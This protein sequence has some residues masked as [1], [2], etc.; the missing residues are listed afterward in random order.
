[1]ELIKLRFDKKWNTLRPS[2]TVQY[3][4]RPP[5]TAP[6]QNSG[7]T[8]NRTRTAAATLHSPYQPLHSYSFTIRLSVNCATAAPD[9]AIVEQVNAPASPSFEMDRKTPTTIKFNG[10]PKRFCWKGE[11]GSSESGPMMLFVHVLWL[12]AAYHDDAAVRV[13]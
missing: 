11:E 6:N 2:H 7:L 9:S 3:H 4:S 8:S 5:T 13:R 12:L 1:M 10:M